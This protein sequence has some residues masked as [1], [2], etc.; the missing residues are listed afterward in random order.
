MLEIRALTTSL[1]NHLSQW[2]ETFV[3]VLEGDE[4]STHEENANHSPLARASE[5]QIPDTVKRKG[6]HQGVGHPNKTGCGKDDMGIGY[7]GT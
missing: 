2:G 1:I 3:K 4:Q 7:A 5:L 6:Q